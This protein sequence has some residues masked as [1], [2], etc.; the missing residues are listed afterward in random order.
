MDELSQ[1]ILC[2][3]S[4]ATTTSWL[5]FANGITS[6]PLFLSFMIFCWGWWPCC[7]DYLIR[8]WSV[9]RLNVE[10][11]ISQQNMV[12]LPQNTKQ[13]YGMKPRPHMQS[14]VLTLAVTLTLNSRPNIQFVVSEDKMIWLAWTENWLYQFNASSQGWPSVL[15]SAMTLTFGLYGQILRKL[16]LW[17]CRADQCEIKRNSDLLVIMVDWMNLWYNN[18]KYW[19]V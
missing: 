3:S 5:T 12:W 18:F 9:S 8:F 2:T 1:L 10:F 14:S 4:C 19:L 13:T 16:C 11:A 15:T 7:I 17:N 6:R